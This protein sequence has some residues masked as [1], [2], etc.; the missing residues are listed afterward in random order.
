MSRNT[1]WIWI[2]VVAFIVV[3]V[4]I[5]LPLSRSSSL[6]SP[7]KGGSVS[8]S[9]QTVPTTRSVTVS[10]TTVKFAHCGGGSTSFGSTSNKLG[11]PNGHCTVGNRNAANYPITVTNTGTRANIQVYTSNA[12]PSD[13]GS[14][15]HPCNI[16]AHP[17]V[18]C[19]GDSG[20][21]PSQDQY[22]LA[23]FSGEGINTSGLTAT[24]TCDYQ[25]DLTRGCLANPGSQQTEG[26]ALTGPSTSTDTSTSWTVQV[27][28]IAV[29]P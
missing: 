6:A 18:G 29:P 17:V 24:A 5:I 12:V 1:A 8:A 14:P 19:G 25:F 9:L 21:K 2:L 4:L 11:F 15:W 10:P 13:G 28:W 16:G 3:A 26:F 22:N 20:K 23:N 7:S 27:T